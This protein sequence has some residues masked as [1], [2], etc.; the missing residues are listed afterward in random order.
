MAFLIMHHMRGNGQI[1]ARLNTANWTADSQN[2]SLTQ[3]PLQNSFHLKNL[4]GLLV[5]RVE[6]ELSLTTHD[7]TSDLRRQR[8]NQGLINSFYTNLRIAHLSYSG[9]KCY[10]C[11]YLEPRINYVRKETLAVIGQE[12]MTGSCNHA[13]QHKGKSIIF[14][15]H[16]EVLYSS[17]ISA[18][19]QH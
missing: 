13:S 2:P 14:L 3:V 6:L 18:I 8:I 7:F 16:P 15:E 4:H 11:L 12:S 9:K 19:W 17:C 5:E 10:I 1:C